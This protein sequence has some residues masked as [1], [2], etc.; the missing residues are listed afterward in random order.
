MLEY[1]SLHN[2]NI[3]QTEFKLLKRER[4]KKFIWK[5]CLLHKQGKEK[6]GEKKKKFIQDFASNQKKL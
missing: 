1:L 3:F 5:F 6:W 4:K 2:L